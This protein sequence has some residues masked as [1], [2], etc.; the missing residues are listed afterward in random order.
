MD[1]L[2]KNRIL[3]ALSDHSLAIPEINAITGFLHNYTNCLVRIT[4]I[5]EDI[6]QS[7]VIQISDIPN[8]V[9]LLATVF[10]ETQIKSREK[11]QIDS[12]II[13]VLIKITAVC[14]LDI[15]SK[16]SIY[17]IHLPENMDPM[18]IESMVN[19]C[20]ELLRMKPM[21]EQHGLDSL[22]LTKQKRKC[23][24]SDWFF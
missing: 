23:C 2:L 13:T 5:L 14:I 12:E 3:Y 11:E 24:Y 22:S 8:I 17:S 21:I 7:N 15:N 9:L 10:Q 19:T 1:T 6:I 20:L 18:V 4:D 16:T